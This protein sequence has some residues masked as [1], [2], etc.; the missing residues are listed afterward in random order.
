MKII[1][2]IVERRIRT[3]ITLNKVLFGFMPGKGTV[4]SILV[5]RRMQ[6]EYQKKDKKLYMC[7]A[8]MEKLLIE[9]KEK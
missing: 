7:F 2:M 9:F 3:L 8:D 6:E 1:E 5:V 4:D